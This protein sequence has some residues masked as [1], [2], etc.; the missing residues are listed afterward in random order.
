MSS[1]RAS[2]SS[3]SAVRQRA[4]PG[5]MPTTESRPRGA[6]TASGS[7]TVGERARAPVTAPA[8][9]FVT[10][11]VPPAPAAASAAASATPW[12]P[13][14]RNTDRRRVGEARR[15]VLKPRGGEKPRRNVEAFGH[16]VD[17]RF[18]RLEIERGDAGE[19]G[20]VGVR[21]VENRFGE[22]HRRLRRSAAFAA[23]AESQ[24][25]RAVEQRVGRRRRRGGRRPRWPA[26]RNRRT[27][28][29]RRRAIPAGRPCGL[30]PLPAMPRR[31]LW[32]VRGWRG[33]S[34]AAVRRGRRPGARRWRR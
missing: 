25:A 27:A 1:A 34:P 26:L 15:F 8:T 30:A 32:R 16:R 29:P 28:A 23:Y 33:S 14:A 6:P 12:Q 20:F 10:A 17:R 18:V 21:R 4:S 3:A 2:A 11:R 22:R 19:G 31:T 9:R 5:P 13:T 24:S 7:M